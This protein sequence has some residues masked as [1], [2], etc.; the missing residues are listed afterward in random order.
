M[1]DVTAWE[2]CLAMEAQLCT[3]VLRQILRLMLNRKA[4]FSWCLFTPI[5]T[6]GGSSTGVAVNGMTWF[7]HI[8]LAEGWFSG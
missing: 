8:F 6:G 7:L 1:G 3:G 2:V 4:S 5:P